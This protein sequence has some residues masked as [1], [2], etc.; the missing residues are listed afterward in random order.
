MSDRRFHLGYFMSFRP[1]AWRSPFASHDARTWADGDYY[2]DF[3]R[4]LDRA[5]FDYMMIED[6][7]MVTD[8]YGGS[9]AFDLKHALYAPKH[10]PMPLVPLLAAATRN[11]GIIATAST[12]FYP[13][14]LL[15]RLMSTLDHLT[16]GRVGW[17]IV[18]SSEDLAAQNYGMDKLPDH[19]ERYERAE[20]FVDLVK[21]LWDSWEPDAL[22]MDRDSGTYV[23]HTRVHPVNF[24]GRWHASRGPLN[25]LRGP[26]GRPVLC[27][28]GSSPRGRDFAAAN[29]DTVIATAKGVAGMRAFRDDIRARAQRFGRDPDTVKILFV[30]SPVLA[31]TDAAARAI[32]DDL[33]RVTD[34]KIEVMLAHLSATTEHD[35]SVY[36]WDQELP[37]GRISTNGHRGSLEEFL[38]RARGRT[39]REVATDWQVGSLDLVGCPDTVAD[40]MGEVMAEVGGDGFLITGRPSTNRTYF[41]QITEGL[42]PALQ[43]RGL[44]R[45]AY[46]HPHLRDN[47]L[48]F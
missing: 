22:V 34:E 12:S 45:T 24:R 29:A 6:S 26:Q 13:P 19:D 10:D 44:V 28:A 2:V 16:R 15:A 40:R 18:T 14:F 25:T 43:R 32:D 35:F 4:A 11:L 38:H 5:G 1:P 21:R 31:P 23:D 17:N 20:E 36:D 9:A 8:I 33:V 41:T 30:A 27:Q 37:E 48:D 42:V 7:S 46:A 47:L 3:A 39:L